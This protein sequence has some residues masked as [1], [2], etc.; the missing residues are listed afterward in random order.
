MD[1]KNT[2]RLFLQYVYLQCH[3]SETKWT[4]QQKA[5]SLRKA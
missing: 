5:A 2:Y 1:G 3:K 4:K